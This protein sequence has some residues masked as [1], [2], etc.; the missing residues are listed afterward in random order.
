MSKLYK[1]DGSTELYN[2]DTRGPQGYAIVEPADIVTALT[3]DANATAADLVLNKSAYVDGVKVTGTN[4][5]LVD[6]TIA[7]DG[8]VAGDIALGKKAY[9]NGVLITG[10]AT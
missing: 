5:N 8:A 7:A 10:T 4:A 1:G 9:V 3:L 6:T 2:T